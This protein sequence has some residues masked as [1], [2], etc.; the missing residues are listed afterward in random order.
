MYRAM[1]M[2]WKLQQLNQFLAIFTLLFSFSNNGQSWILSLK[3]QPITLYR[4][5]L[6]F[7]IF[8]F[9][10][11]AKERVK[12]QPEFECGNGY[13]KNRHFSPLLFCI[14]QSLVKFI[15]VFLYIFCLDQYIFCIKRTSR[16][17]NIGFRDVCLNPYISFP[18]HLPRKAQ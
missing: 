18:F 5:Y 15:I 7:K 8:S 9:N 4:F 1:L 6:A 13:F 12:T 10:L 14:F 3:N 17:R 2:C 11:P 16:L